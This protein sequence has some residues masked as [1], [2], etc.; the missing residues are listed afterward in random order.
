MDP[1]AW[2]A[3]DISGTLSRCKVLV[4]PVLCS[5][6]FAVM[7][8]NF[9]RDVQKLLQWCLQTIAVMFSHVLKLEGLP[10]GVLVP[11]F[12][13]KIALCSHVPTL[14]QNVFVL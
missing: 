14:S 7:F 8:T 12:P 11:L 3:I 4:F 9:C 6:T 1:T 13:S 2:E 5:E 10:G